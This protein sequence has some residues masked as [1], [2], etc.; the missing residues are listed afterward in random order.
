[1]QNHDGYRLSGRRTAREDTRRFTELD[2]KELHLKVAIEPRPSVLVG[3][4]GH[5]EPELFDRLHCRP[6][7]SQVAGLADIAVCSDCITT[8]DV[9]AG[10]RSSKD[11][12][13]NRSQAP[14]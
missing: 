7:L 6:K 10:M 12:N 13:R 2:S 9:L 8:S 3:E 1:M 11:D 5:A 4:A 14:V